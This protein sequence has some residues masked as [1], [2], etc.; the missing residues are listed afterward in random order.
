MD[1]FGPRFV[2]KFLFIKDLRSD[3]IHT[4]LEATLGATMY[5]LTKVKEWVG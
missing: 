1:K 5:S 3:A 2:I 4:E